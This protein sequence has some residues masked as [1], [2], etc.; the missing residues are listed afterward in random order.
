MKIVIIEDEPLTADDLAD[1]LREVDASIQVVAQL[2]S[3]QE[4]VAYFEQNGP[5]DL[6]FSDIQLSDGLS[7]ELFKR[8]KIS[9]PVIFCTAFDEYAIQAFKA[10]GIDY[11]MKP[12]SRQN[13]ADALAKYRELKTRFSSGAL[14]YESIMDLL[15]KKEQPTQASVLVFYKDQILPVKTQDVALFYIHNEVTHLKTFKGEDYLLDDN[16]DKLEQ[17]AGSNFYRINRQFLVNRQAIKSASRFFARKLIV[18][19]TVEHSESI[20][21][22]KAK[23]SPFLQWLAGNS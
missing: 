17:V 10:N 11:I 8:I 13:V 16:L 3:V 5:P 9:T 19:L 4:S 14:S 18:I 23:V 12:F 15:T 7:F 2:E 1:A 20:V 22:S 21:V 6:I